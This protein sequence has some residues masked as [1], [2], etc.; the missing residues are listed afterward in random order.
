MN[1]CGRKQNQVFSP[2]HNFGSSRWKVWSPFCFFRWNKTGNDTTLFSYNYFLIRNFRE[3]TIVSRKKRWRQINRYTIAFWDTETNSESI[4]FT[5]VSGDMVVSSGIN[6]LEIRKIFFWNVNVTSGP[7]R[8][9]KTISPKI[10]KPNEY[11]YF[12]LV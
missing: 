6:T 5:T 2:D 7:L 12:S 1:I 9:T 11:F 8:N 3:Y 10:Q 4:T